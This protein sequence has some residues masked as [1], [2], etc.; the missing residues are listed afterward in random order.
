MASTEDISEEEYDILPEASDWPDLE[1]NILAARQL[2]H[3][4][5]PGVIYAAWAHPDSQSIH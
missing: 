3:R 4:Q 1:L 5:T 2:T